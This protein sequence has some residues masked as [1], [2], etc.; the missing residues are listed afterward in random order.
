MSAADIESKILA[1]M[2]PEFPRKVNNLIVT[3]MRGIV[4]DRFGYENSING[5]TPVLLLYFFFDLNISLI[6][7][8]GRYP[9]SKEFGHH[10]RRVLEG[11]AAQARVRLQNA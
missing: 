2:Q 4:W 3:N 1:R 6:F 8:V 10:W 11:V 7:P 9:H 5:F